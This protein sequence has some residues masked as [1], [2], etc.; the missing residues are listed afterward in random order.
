M[1]QIDTVL[2]DLQR[3]NK[4]NYLPFLLQSDLK[5]KKNS[6]YLYCYI[7]PSGT[8]NY[9]IR[10]NLIMR[11]DQEDTTLSY[12]LYIYGPRQGIHTDG[13]CCCYFFL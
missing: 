10:C 7:R 2:I 9:P 11:H 8:K 3:S 6:R 1:T 4:C 5:K 12:D 13:C